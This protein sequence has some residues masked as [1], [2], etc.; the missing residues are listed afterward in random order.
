VRWSPVAVGIAGG[1]IG[2]ASVLLGA[3]DPHQRVLDLVVGWLLIGVGSLASQR[4]P[5][6][7]TGALV[8]AAGFAWFVGDVAWVVGPFALATVV[9]PLHRGLLVHAILSY[10]TGRLET[11]LAR[12]VT[13]T[14]YL[15]PLVLPLGVDRVVTAGLLLMVAAVASGVGTDARAAH[16]REHLTATHAAFILAAGPLMQLAA[17]AALPLGDARRVGA[18]VYAAAVAVAACRL[19]SDLLRT[20]GG[21]VTDL[22]VELA[23]R[24]G[25]VREA[26]A[27]ALGDPSVQV[28]YVTAAGDGYV[29]DEGRRLPPEPG[30]GRVAT[31]IAV[32][33]E[34][35][36][37]VVHTRP[38]VEDPRLLTAFSAAVGLASRNARLQAQVRGRIAEV[39]ASRQRLLSVA[40]EE[41]RRLSARLSEGP[42]RRLEALQ[43]QLGIVEHLAATTPEGP[44][45][46]VREVR[47]QLERVLADLTEVARGLHPVPLQGGLTAALT[48]LAGRSAF[49][50]ELDVDVG[51][52]PGEL[53][54]VV[55]YVCAEA[56]ANVTK[57]AA[58]TSAVVAVHRG[59][60]VEIVVADDG[61]GGADLAGGTGLAGLRDR[62]GAFGGELAVDSPAGGGTRL[63]ASV[64][65]AEAV[66]T[67]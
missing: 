4:A 8:A 26:L 22:V 44:T 64:P 34:Q 58:A 23:Q 30:D 33:G 25:G 47:D 59:A 24:R 32:D 3:G 52:L 35:V 49:P 29:D 18:V 48:D 41:R 56:L 57:H 15:S 45:D 63:R 46:E 7:P 50:V 27:D 42:R 17:R 31:P 36:G 21:E 40:D 20:R 60:V 14:V 38:I 39:S 6:R 53:E 28:G 55:Y 54:A 62:I 61:V 10:P 11:P 13:A 66:A 67:W 37:V 19:V 43:E 5:G 9:A 16:V 51:P 1:V 65:V 2:A 12:I